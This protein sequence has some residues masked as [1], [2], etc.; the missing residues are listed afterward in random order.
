MGLI[1]VLGLVV[2]IEIKGVV[3][4]EG[5]SNGTEDRM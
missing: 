5:Q 3:K 1:K 4:L 2:L